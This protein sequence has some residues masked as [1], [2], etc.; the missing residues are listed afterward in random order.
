M[1]ITIAIAKQ[2]RKA[3]E[4]GF[5]GT[6]P[7]TNEAMIRR[8]LKHKEMQRT[9]DGVMYNI[10]DLGEKVT[11]KLGTIPIDPVWGRHITDDVT[12]CRCG[13]ETDYRLVAWGEV[14]A[15]YQDGNWV[16]TV[17]CIECATEGL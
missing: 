6:H 5:Y 8:G 17:P 16:Q 11:D 2:L 9:P 10:S 13:Q 4:V 15:D 14:D 12:C 7:K 3:R 1:K